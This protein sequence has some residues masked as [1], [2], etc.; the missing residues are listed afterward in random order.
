MSKDA[1]RSFHWKMDPETK[2]LKIKTKV[3]GI[4]NRLEIQNDWLKVFHKK[5][6]KIKMEVPF[7]FSAEEEDEF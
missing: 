4:E 2:T 7:S 6:L 3:P 5:N 1:E